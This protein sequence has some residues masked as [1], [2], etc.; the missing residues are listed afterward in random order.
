MP[1]TLI[2]PPPGDAFAARNEYA[3]AIDYREQPPLFRITDTH[4]AAT[5]LLD[6][7]APKIVPPV[8]GLWHEG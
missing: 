7:R 4:F 5:W 6:P 3:L 1:P 8:G 2:A